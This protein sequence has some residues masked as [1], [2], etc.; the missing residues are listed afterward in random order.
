MT[1]MKQLTLVAIVVTVLATA[2]LTLAIS[3]ASSGGKP[4]VSPPAEG[5]SVPTLPGQSP[6]PSSFPD[7]NA[8][9]AIPSGVT[10]PDAW[11]YFDNP[12]MHY[13][14]CYPADWGFSDFSSPKRFTQV[15]GESLYSV[16]LLS[17]DYF[18]SWPSSD[19][20]RLNSN[21]VT[22]TIESFPPGLTR[23]GCDPTVKIDIAGVGATWCQDTYDLLPGPEVKFAPGGA[24]HTLVVAAPLDRSPEVDPVIPR[25]AQ[26][27]QPTSGYRLLMTMTAPTSRYLTEGTLQWQIIKTLRLD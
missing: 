20:E 19:E 12:V 17:P 18:S 23:Q 27:S 21:A 13:S 25:A 14:V 6:T 2:G 3:W 15:P 26:D 11:L 7:V 8:S 10:C 9:Q 1:R 22:L 5:G 4:T 16:N 24:R